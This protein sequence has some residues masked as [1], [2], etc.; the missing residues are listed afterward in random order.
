MLDHLPPARVVKP[1]DV[2]RIGPDGDEIVGEPLEL[3]GPKLVDVRLKPGW[4]PRFVAEGGTQHTGLAVCGAA[5]QF[6][7][8]AVERLLLHLGQMGE[9]LL[10]VRVVPAG[11]DEFLRQTHIRRLGP[12]GGGG[13]RTKMAKR[14]LWQQDLAGMRGSSR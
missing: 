10:A 12:H 2:A 5:G 13:Q 14:T 11:G 7:H 4:L 6:Q 1:I 8:H 9:Q 3:A